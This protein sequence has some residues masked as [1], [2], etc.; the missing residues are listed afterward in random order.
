MAEVVTLTGDVTP[1]IT[2]V[3]KAGDNTAKV[4]HKV[5]ENQ[6]TDTLTFEEGDIVAYLTDVGEVGSS[7]ETSEFKVFHAKTFKIPKGES[8]KDLQLTEALTKNGL[9][10]IRKAYKAGSYIVTAFFDESG[11]QL[12]GCIGAI[13]DWGMTMSNGDACTLTYTLAISNDEIKCEL[14]TV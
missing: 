6:P 1:D 4:Y 13:T 7:K 9:E 11:N 2:K 12:Y 8:A 5:V 14:P 10:N 3:V